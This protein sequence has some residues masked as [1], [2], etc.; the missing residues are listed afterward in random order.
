M[1]Q[2]FERQT[3]IA[4]F[5]VSFNIVPERWLVIYL[6]NSSCV[7]LIAKWPAKRSY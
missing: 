5:D 6:A 2:R 3:Y 7:F 1:R 4:A